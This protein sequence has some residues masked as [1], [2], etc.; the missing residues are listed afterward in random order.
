MANRFRLFYWPVNRFQ[1]PHL[2]R[3]RTLLL[4]GW[5]RLRSREAFRACQ[6]QSLRRR[7]R[8]RAPQR[9][10]GRL[11]NMKADIPLEKVSYIDSQPISQ[12]QKG[13]PLLLIEFHTCHFV[14]P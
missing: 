4:T 13:L 8:H 14:R 11:Q 6:R 10:P 1:W 3:E 2:I 7:L 5:A 9:M 12:S